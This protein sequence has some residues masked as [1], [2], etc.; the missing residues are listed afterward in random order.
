MENFENGRL[1]VAPSERFAGEQHAFELKRVVAEL[2]AENH[3]AQSG[4]RQMTLLHQGAV[5]MVVFAFE[6]GGVMA[7]HAA[8]GL[9]TIQVIEGD[10]AIET[11]AQSHRLAAGSLL[12]LQP[13]VRHSVTAHAAGAFLLTVAMERAAT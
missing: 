6:N 7:D 9:V 1:R 3:P 10:F 5:T 12:V 13:D 8:H 11:P 4:H 2:R